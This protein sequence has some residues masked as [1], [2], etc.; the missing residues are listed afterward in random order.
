MRLVRVSLRD[1]RGVTESTVGLGDGVTVVEG[2][3]EVGKSSIAEAIRLVRGLKAS[4]RRRSVLSVQPVGRDVGPEVELELRTGAYD[5]VLRKR[6]LRSPLTELTVR[7]PEPEHLTGDQAHDRYLAILAETVDVALLDALD[8]VQGESLDQPG[9][10]QITA[11]HRALDSSSGELAGHDALLERIEQEHGRY[12]TATGRMT[13]DYKRA[14]EKVASFESEVAALTAR[15]AEMDQLTDEHARE[16]ARLEELTARLVQAQENLRAREAEGEALAALRRGAEDSARVLVESEREREVAV[17]ALA[18]REQQA[19]D[20]AG[21]SKE[22]DELAARVETLKQDSEHL[23]TELDS[24][25]E[26]VAFYQLRRRE[27][28]ETAKAASS[29]L[30]RRRDRAEHADLADRV[31]RARRASRQRVEAMAV[32]ADAVID[33]DAV[34]H[35][36]ALETNVRVAEGARTAA[37]GR[38]IVRA[39]GDRSVTV[40]GEAVPQDVAYESAVLEP[41]LIEVEGVLSA[42]VRPGAPPAELE[43]S[44]TAS[45]DALDSALRRVGVESVDQAREVAGRRRQA[46][47]D[48]DR[49]AAALDVA[50]AGSALDALEERLAA[51]AARLERPDAAD[52][53][54]A[55]EE[56][57]DVDLAALELAAESA[58]SEEA[59]ADG[60]LEAAR[61]AQ[62][63]ARTAAD[64]VRDAWGRASGELVAK[65][66]EHSKAAEALARARAARED[67]A[68]HNALARAQAAVEERRAVAEADRAALD[69]SKPEVHE[70]R[71][72]NARDLAV[73]TA[74]QHSTTSKRVD[75]LKVLLDDRAGQGIY[76]RLASAQAGL[77]A[78]LSGHQRLDRAAQA[79][80]LLR[81]TMLRHRDEAQSR[82]VAPFTERIDRLGR[83]V[84]GRDFA[85]HVT[86]DLAIASRTLDGQTVPFGSL[87][88]GARE[89][90]ALLGRLA[91]AQLVDA[92][93]GA[94]VILDDTLGFADPERLAALNVVLNDV[95]R[96]VQVVL[97]TCQPDRFATLGGAHNV[98]LG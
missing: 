66:N 38:V 82:Y 18:E 55:A 58:G 64:A 75:G 97:L 69:A 32:L 96:T 54:A 3:N 60:E 70:M 91:C 27:A 1:F 6:W 79:V 15:S 40:G 87:S 84:F 45:R 77:D 49:A 23:A 57:D 59:R 92:E 65:R 47:M 78:A 43:R 14:A 88:A 42:E 4:S 67:A 12:F 30:R 41:V 71:L 25:R 44:V 98:R 53:T 34:G 46:E 24:G 20:L 28:Y 83:I 80:R 2:P 50:L 13:G 5:L 94:P 33:D 31:E 36:F 74:E 10:A 29:A 56:A 35:L 72:R 48:R 63:A 81:T 17:A 73:S 93:E 22:V 21:R 61:A 37:A 19:A 52:R 9:L 89:Q 16:A 85:V 51:V 68:L 90:L 39:L 11:L 26:A 95:G 86:R 62:E 76:D 7:A 8:V